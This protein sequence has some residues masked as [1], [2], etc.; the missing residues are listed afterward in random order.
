MMMIIINMNI[1]CKSR[2]GKMHQC[3]PVKSLVATGS[4]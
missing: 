1:R 4:H 2:R 3:P